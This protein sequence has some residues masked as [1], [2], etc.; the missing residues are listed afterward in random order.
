MGSEGC[1]GL[2]TA[3]SIAHN[4]SALPSLT[5]FFF[6]PLY[7]IMAHTSSFPAPLPSPLLMQAFGVVLSMILLSLLEA[8]T[9]QIDNLVLPVFGVTLLNL[10]YR[11]ARDSHHGG[12]LT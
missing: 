5:T 6:P 11:F 9:C 4:F 10:A 7:L 1:G 2:K 8:F 12:V 3:L